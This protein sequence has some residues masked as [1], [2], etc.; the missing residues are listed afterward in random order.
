M[1]LR[2]ICLFLNE[3]IFFMFVSLNTISLIRHY[4]WN[5]K[6]FLTG[7]GA[8]FQRPPEEGFPKRCHAVWNA[9]PGGVQLAMVR[10]RIDIN[11]LLSIY[12]PVWP[13]N[14]L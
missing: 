10:S 4:D 1:N 7:S 9:A 5:H 6:Y 11:Q 3:I 14:L 13:V 8:W 2:V 12:N